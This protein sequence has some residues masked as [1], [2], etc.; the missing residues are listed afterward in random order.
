MSDVPLRTRIDGAIA[1]VTGGARG[2]DRAVVLSL[3]DG[4][5]VVIADL[6][7]AASDEVAA[8]VAKRGGVLLA[9]SVQ[10]LSPLPLLTR[11]DHFVLNKP[12]VSNSNIASDQNPNGV[13]DRSSRILL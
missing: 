7:V 13:G 1:V 4:A 10:S 2:F 11:N 9:D 3:V 12:R 5:R 8:Q 6:D